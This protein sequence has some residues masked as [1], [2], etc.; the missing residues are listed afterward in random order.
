MN[1]DEKRDAA[2]IL[3]TLLEL[4]DAEAD[5]DIFIGKNRVTIEKIITHLIPE[6]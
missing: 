6:E 4:Y 2:L 3:C 5:V 1:E